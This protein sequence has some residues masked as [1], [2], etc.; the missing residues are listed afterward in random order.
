MD[1]HRVVDG[2]GLISA[3]CR[4]ELPRLESVDQKSTDVGIEIVGLDHFDVLDFTISRDHRGQ[5]ADA[6][7]PP[8]RKAL[9]QR[10]CCRHPRRWH[11]VVGDMKRLSF[12]LL[13]VDFLRSCGQLEGHLVCWGG[14]RGFIEI[15][16]P[17]LRS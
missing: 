10:S 3:G 9:Q 12:G 11:D 4:F 2:D 15:G 16:I 7:H 17:T 6:L 5:Y 1:S 13:N 14:L 8:T